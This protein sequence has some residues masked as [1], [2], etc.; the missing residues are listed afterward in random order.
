MARKYRKLGLR[1]DKNLA[2]VDNKYEALSNV[3]NG[4]AG[5]GETFLP[6]DIAVI[7][8]LRNTNVTSTD[9][10]QVKGLKLY[11]LV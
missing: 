11:H 9:F 8:N 6:E 4:L 3:L 1:R 5:P 2:D 7:N 10:A